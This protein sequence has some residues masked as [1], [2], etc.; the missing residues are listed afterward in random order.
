M[1]MW[2]GD[3]GANIY[4]RDV[5][6]KKEQFMAFVFVGAMAQDGNDVPLIMELANE[7]SE[8]KIP[9][10]VMN[11]A[12]VFLAFCSGMSKRPYHWMLA[13]GC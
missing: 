2:R 11:A 10:N 4:E 8:E 1:S 7:I 13:R 3:D 5:M 9:D 12:K 6:S